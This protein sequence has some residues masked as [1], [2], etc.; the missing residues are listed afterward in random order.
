ME[1]DNRLDELQAITATKKQV[2]LD[3]V[4]AHLKH[5]LAELDKFVTITP[6]KQFQAM[7]EEDIDMEDGDPNHTLDPLDGDLASEEEGKP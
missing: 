1:N 6:V 4:R 5:Y 7:A 2:K 3:C